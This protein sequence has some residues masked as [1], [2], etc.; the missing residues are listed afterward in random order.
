MCDQEKTNRLKAQKEEKSQEG[1]ENQ[2]EGYNA[3]PVGL[4]LVTGEPMN[5]DA[6]S[7]FDNYCVKKQF[8]NL[9]SILAEQLLL[10]DEVI[11]AGREMK[12]SF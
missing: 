1:S 2:L 9:T 7:I 3:Q 5:P 6:L 12:K 11:K 8:L 10:V 4:D